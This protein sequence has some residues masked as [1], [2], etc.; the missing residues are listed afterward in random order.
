MLVH[1][2]LTNSARLCAAW[3]EFAL[4]TLQRPAQPNLRRAQDALQ[5]IGGT[6]A[7]EI[8]QVGVLN[9]VRR[10]RGFRKDIGFPVAGPLGGASTPVRRNGTGP[11]R[12]KARQ[13][14]ISPIPAEIGW[15]RRVYLG[16]GPLVRPHRRKSFIVSPFE[17]SE[18]PGGECN[19]QPKSQWQSEANGPASH[20]GAQAATRGPSHWH[21]GTAG[22]CTMT[23]MIIVVRC[24]R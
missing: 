23:I 15:M 22:I 4:R 5:K 17:R 14:H 19:L 3:V 8:D 18:C 11:S 21:D 24:W 12:G 16:R 13:G 9:K 1:A 2:I 20:S 10:K 6:N 7:H